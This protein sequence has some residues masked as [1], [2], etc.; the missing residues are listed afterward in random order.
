MTLHSTNPAAGDDGVRQGSVPGGNAAENNGE[1][2]AR[3]ARNRRTKIMKLSPEGAR[4]LDAAL[5]EKRG[6]A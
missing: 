4:R 3:Q 1:H 5:A 6:A 2:L